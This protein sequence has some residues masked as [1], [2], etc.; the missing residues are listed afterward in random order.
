[1]N[2]TEKITPTP[3]KQSPMNAMMI[4]GAILI[5]G[6]LVAGAV[7][8]SGQQ[9]SSNLA[10][11]QGQAAQVVQQPTGNTD[12]VNPVTS[13]DHIR[14]SID[15][16]VKIVEF[17]DFE[18]PFCKRLHFTMKEVMDEYGESGQVA[19]VY[20]QFPLDS[21]HPVKAR[22]ESIIS[23]CVADIGGNDAFWTFTDR[24]FELSPSNNRTDLDVVIP[25]IIGELGL[26][27]SAIDQCVASGKYDQHV[28]DDVEN[29]I[30]TGGRGTPWS[31][32]IGPNG[33][34][35]PLSGAQSAASIKQIIE[36]A[37]KTQ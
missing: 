14:G 11:V 29:A 7:I 12:N 17:S 34:T 6:L 21:L 2:E 30:A 3:Q 5:T 31:V 25:Q 35:Y 8:Y 22:L 32:V 19:W 24:F 37:L 36:I 13:E 1:M 18:C 4:P 33:D 16:P 28:Q 20:R 27:Q 9:G 15:A 23:E 10:N 26:S